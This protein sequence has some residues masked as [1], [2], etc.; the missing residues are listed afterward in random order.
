V[1]AADKNS[2][3]Q[4]ICSF[5]YLAY[6]WNIPD[7]IALARPRSVR[8]VFASPTNAPAYGYDPYGVPLQTTASLTDFGYVGLL[9]EPDSGLGLATYRAY[10]PSVGRWTSRDPIGERG[11]R[12]GNLYGY[13]GQSVVNRVDPLGL[14]TIQVGGTISGQFALVNGQVGIGIAIDSSGNVAGYTSFGGGAG[15]GGKGSASV[16]VSVSTAST[17][18]D[19]KG[20]FANQSIAGGVIASGS[21]DMF[22]GVESDAIITGGGVS[23]GIGAGASVTDAVTITIVHPWGVTW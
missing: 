1:Y 9:N 4:S 7:C 16:G 14:W 6:F 12:A 10:D 17:V 21:V 13:V 19:L 23:V 8:R 15:V 20:P 3:A 18:C 2:Y 5:R 11:D 22:E